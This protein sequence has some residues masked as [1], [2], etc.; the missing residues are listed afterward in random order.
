MARARPGHSHDRER[1]DDMILLVAF[2][3]AFASLAEAAIEAEHPSD[4]VR[5]LED[6]EPSQWDE[7][8]SGLLGDDDDLNAHAVASVVRRLPFLRPEVRARVAGALR[9]HRHTLPTLWKLAVEDPEP[10]VRE[11]AMDSLLRTRAHGCVSRPHRARKPV[12]HRRPSRPREQ[13]RVP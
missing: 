6:G 9:R 3:I 12:P 8:V 10:T 13:V 1:D 2:T 11:T 7:A 4:Y 5:V